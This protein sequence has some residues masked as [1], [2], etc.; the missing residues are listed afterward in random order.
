MD[1][2]SHQESIMAVRQSAADERDPIL[3]ETRK[4]QGNNDSSVEVNLTSAGRDILG[5]EP[6]D[7]LEVEVYGDRIALVPRE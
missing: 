7:E 4:V 2:G 3:T 6:G 5:I 1:S